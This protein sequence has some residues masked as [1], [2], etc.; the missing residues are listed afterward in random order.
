MSILEKIFAGEAKMLEVATCHFI[1][2]QNP[3]VS[4]FREGGLRKKPACINSPEDERLQPSFGLKAARL[5]L[6][7]CSAADGRI[8]STISSATIPSVRLQPQLDSIHVRVQRQS[9]PLRQDILIP[10]CRVSLQWRQTFWAVFFTINDRYLVTLCMDNHVGQ[11]F[12]PAVVPP[13]IARATARS[14]PQSL[15]LG[16]CFVVS[17]LAMTE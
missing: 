1:A 7:A 16:D 5:R 11:A 9:A 13:V 15:S 8:Q 10:H 6:A 2:D 3:P 14:N 17:L 4:S 12:Q